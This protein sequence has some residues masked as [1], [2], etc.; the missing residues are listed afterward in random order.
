MFQV[1]VLAKISE[2]FDK[3][4]EKTVI[5]LKDLNNIDSLSAKYY[6]FEIDGQ[7]F[8]LNKDCGKNVF[9]NIDYFINIISSEENSLKIL[10]EENV[11]ICPILNE[12][13]KEL[14]NDQ[15]EKQKESE[16]KTVKVETIK[17]TYNRMLKDYIEHNSQE[18]KIE[19]CRMRQYYEECEVDCVFKNMTNNILN[20]K[21]NPE[22]FKEETMN[23]YKNKKVEIENMINDIKK[24]NKDSKNNFNSTVENNLKPI[25]EEVIGNLL[26]YDNSYI[27]SEFNE[28]FNLYIKLISDIKKRNL[29]V[30][31]NLIYLIN[32]LKINRYPDKEAIYEK[33]EK[34]SE[35]FK[36][37]ETLD[38]EIRATNIIKPLKDQLSSI[39][40]K[41]S[42]KPENNE[43]L[44]KHKELLEN[45]IKLEEE[46]LKPFRERNFLKMKILRKKVKLGINQNC[47]QQQV[48]Y[49]D[50][51]QKEIE[52]LECAE[53]LEMMK[54][55]IASGKKISEYPD[56]SD[57]DKF[58]ILI[59]EITGKDIEE[60]RDIT[61]DNWDNNFQD[62][63]ISKILDN[64]RNELKNK[65][66]KLD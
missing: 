53:K 3:Q 49:Y 15:I 38:N 4:G 56:S 12:E 44:K 54:I 10:K 24:T 66:R 31:P 11:S 48:Q 64:F 19:L 18:K 30:E 7:N 14:L 34:L 20:G 25:K 28:K 51:L 29:N 39:N 52:M 47:I 63:N 37:L 22:T 26:S 42:E 2:I 50:K 13:L 23:L 33:L 6:I 43:L 65:K 17:K 62:K 59:K 36:N 41:L 40:T 1:K 61:A 55:F 58:E 35:L 27:S 16:K 60:I 46:K 32:Y 21:E 8:G 45:K 57:K 9:F 5:L